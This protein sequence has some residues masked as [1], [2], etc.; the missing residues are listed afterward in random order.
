MS[1][2]TTLPQAAYV[3]DAFAGFRGDADFDLGSGRAMMWMSQLA[4]ETADPAKVAAI[5]GQWGLET[6]VVDGG[7][8]GLA[9]TQAVVARRG[10]GAVIVAFAG[11]DPV[12]AADWVSDFDCYLDPATGI[13]RGY[14]RAAAVVMGRIAAMLDPAAAL[15]VTGHSLGGALAAVAS[16]QLAEGGVRPRAVHTFG[17]PRPGNAAFAARYDA[18]LGSCT[19]RLVH[20]DDMVPTVA[21][22]FLGFRHV[23]RHLSC[24]RGMRFDI[25]LMAADATSDEPAFRIDGIGSLAGGGLPVEQ[26]MQ[27]FG[28]DRTVPRLAAMALDML[29]S[30]I[31][32][33][34]PDRY[35]AGFGDRIDLG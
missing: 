27:A 3:P 13:A 30:G 10:D 14:Q 20:G 2:L 22:S 8:L 35:L 16:M 28:L 18:M 32:D 15:F 33:H 24:R 1:I 11:T 7:R 4:Y 21:P 5:G 6:E 29:P 9:R 34:L 12:E 23:G 19:Y 17:M 26:M 25:G 31:R